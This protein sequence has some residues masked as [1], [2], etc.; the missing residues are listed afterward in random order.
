MT[1]KKENKKVEWTTSITKIRPN[2][3]YVRGYKIEDL[4]E[5]LNFGEAVYLILQGKLPKN[6][7]YGKMMNVFLISIIDYGIGAP[8]VCAARYVASSLLPHSESEGVPLAFDAAVAAGLSAFA[9]YHGGAPGGAAKWLQE[10]VKIMRNDGKSAE[11][12]A[13][14]IANRH[15]AKKERIQGYGHPHHDIADPRSV[16]L[17]EL[18]KRYE[19][20]GDHWELN[21]AMEK[22]IPKVYGRKF[23]MNAG[24]AL[25]AT[26]SDLGFNWKYGYGL[27]AIARI[28][29]LVAHTYEEMTTCKPFRV[30]SSK[31]IEYVGHETRKFPKDYNDLS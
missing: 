15:K 24:A 19:V 25:G 7:N 2:K 13:E 5:N 10:G 21:E 17:R 29:G 31:D 8:S 1:K 16:K 20:F 26:L 6:K 28:A 11:E 9:I 30:P 3:I 23:I 18:A 12:V 14:E 4:M 27:F 22:I